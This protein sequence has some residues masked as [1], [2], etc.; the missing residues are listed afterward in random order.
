[1]FEPPLSARFATAADADWLYALHRSALGPYVAATWGWEEDKQQALF[2]QNF[3][4][5]SVLILLY[6]EQEIG[7]LAIREEP[8]CLRLHN[9]QLLP[10]RQRQ[11]LGSQLLR[12]LQEH[13]R[14]R[15]LPL[16]LQVLRV[17]P[18]RHLYDRLGFRETG[19]TPTHFHLC[20]LP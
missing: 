8:D 19:E 6:N 10:D 20:W 15:Q 13:C 3:Q 1:M 9:V 14:R 18:A 4:P 16:C 12:A 2:Q 5:E 11:G 7:M 17:N